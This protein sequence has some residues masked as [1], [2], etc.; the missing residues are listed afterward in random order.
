MCDIDLGMW[1]GAWD[2]ASHAT[3]SASANRK[4][5][6]CSEDC[7]VNDMAIREP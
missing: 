4:T 1:Y 3:A 7:D 2:T 5:A 6:M